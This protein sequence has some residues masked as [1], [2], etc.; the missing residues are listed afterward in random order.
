MN[1]D[2]KIQVVVRTCQV[3]VGT[4]MVAVPTY[5]TSG[6]FLG[7]RTNRAVLFDTMLDDSHQKAIKEGHRLSCKLGLE[8]EV[9]DAS[10]L[11][12]LKRALLS[13]QRRTSPGPALLVAPTT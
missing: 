12:I 5:T 6:V 3:P 7:L 9:V 4:I 8:F 13:A 11:G 1:P 10:K 2:D